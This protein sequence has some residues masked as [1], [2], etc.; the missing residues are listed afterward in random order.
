[1]CDN[2]IWL[3]KISKICG[4]PP[5]P[6]RPGEIPLNSVNTLDWRGIYPY[7]LSLIIVPA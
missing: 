4:S 1:M 7:E 5:A 6:P 3:P 2:K